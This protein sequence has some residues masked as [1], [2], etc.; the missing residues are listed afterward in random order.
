MIYIEKNLK[1]ELHHNLICEVAMIKR[2]FYAY[3]KED[4][5][6]IINLKDISIRV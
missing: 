2:Y 3:E 4:T 6:R 5:R 1:E